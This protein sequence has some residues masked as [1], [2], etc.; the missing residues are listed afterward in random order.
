MP[1]NFIDVPEL[2]FSIEREEKDGKRLYKVPSGALYPSVTT[3]L[4]EMNKK[5]IVEW[6]NR[7]GA[8]EA[9]RISGKASTR[10]TKIHKLCEDYILGKPIEKLNPLHKE[11]FNQLRKKLDECVNNIH[12][13]ESKLYSDRLKLAGTVDLIAEYD[14][15]LSVIDFKT[16]SK[17]KKESYILNYFYQTTIYSLMFEEL[18]SLK[19]KQLV[20]MIAVEGETHPQIFIKKRKDYINPLLEFLKATK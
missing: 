12:G 16:S 14:G 9:N 7:V 6:R 11:M 18:T 10:G 2:N 17:L 8:E 3:V 5:V 13:L 19:A 15:E 20:I 1:F 4:S